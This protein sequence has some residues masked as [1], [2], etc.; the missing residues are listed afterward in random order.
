MGLFSRKPRLLPLEV[1]ALDAQLAPGVD[2][3]SFAAQ[4]VYQMGYREAFEPEAHD[5]VDLLIEDVLD[6]VRLDVSA[7]DEPYLRQLLAT[8]AQIGAGIGL[9]ERR[10]GQLPERLIDKDIEGALRAA[11]IELPKMPPEQR[12]VACFLIRFGHY[13]ARNGPAS[14][15]V[16]LAGL[17]G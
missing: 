3:R 15:P 17:R 7:E 1:P 4:A 11:A 6:A 9:V 13:V 14:I 16:V 12:R 8:A 5:V 10:G 2:A